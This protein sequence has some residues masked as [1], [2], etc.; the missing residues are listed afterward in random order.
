MS[1]S[2]ITQPNI[3]IYVVMLISSHSNNSLESTH[4]MFSGFPSFTLYL[5]ILHLKSLYC[6]YHLNELNFVNI[7]TIHI[8]DVSIIILVWIF[9]S[10]QKYYHNKFKNHF[11]LAETHTLIQK[12][13]SSKKEHTASRFFICNY[14]N[15]HITSTLC[16]CVILFSIFTCGSSRWY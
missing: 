4:K 14:D 11:S 16:F 12:R 15:V 6:V 8:C 10:N 7:A 2:I 13:I 3:F 9:N 1:N 5:C